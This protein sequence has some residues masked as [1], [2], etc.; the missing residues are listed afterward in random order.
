MAS[1]KLPQ[2]S[3]RGRNSDSPGL[4]RARVP[5][6]CAPL[7]DTTAEGFGADVLDDP[8]RRIQPTG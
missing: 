3:R 4:A 6:S 5:Q 2:A 8:A 7:H 1:C